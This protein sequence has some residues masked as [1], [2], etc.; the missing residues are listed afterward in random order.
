MMTSIVEWIE[1]HAVVLT[2]CGVALSLLSIVAVFAMVMML[3][4]DHF[5]R[6]DSPEAFSRRH[7]ALRLL[8]RIVKN[9][10]GAI[11]FVLGVIMAVPMVPGPGVVF[12]V[13]GISL[14]DMPGKRALK[15]Y[16]IRQ[17]LVLLPINTLR[18]KW[19]RPPLQ[20]PG[21]APQ[22]GDS[23][24]PA[25]VPAAARPAPAA[26]NS[27]KRTPTSKVPEPVAASSTVSS[28]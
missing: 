3:R 4:P 24:A 1:G 15:R 16:I 20:V 17:P 23:I 7:P 14:T 21:A 19:R 26:A 18:A 6:P 27:P 5:T 11:L 22:P 28:D 25:A 9:F 2:S 8:I 13:L 12:I 10:V